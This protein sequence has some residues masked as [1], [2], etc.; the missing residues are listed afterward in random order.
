[1]P[2]ENF[3]ARRSS[4]GFLDDPPVRAGDIQALLLE[5]GIRLAVD[6]S[7]PKVPWAVL[8]NGTLSGLTRGVYSCSRAGELRPL[9]PHMHVGM[10]HITSAHFMEF[11]MGQTV[12]EH[13]S[14][15]MLLCAHR[16]ASGAVDDLM[17]QLFCAGAVAQAVYLRAA[18]RRIGITCIGAF[19]DALA[20]E[21]GWIAEDVEILNVLA[22]GRDDGSATIKWDRKTT[23]AVSR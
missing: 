20:H 23:A 18:E 13:A 5:L 16:E 17:M 3:L 15:L 4:C 7:F 11:T 14:A 19:D 21:Y 8:V 1:M 22:L 6:H 10:E 2:H 12:V 9:H